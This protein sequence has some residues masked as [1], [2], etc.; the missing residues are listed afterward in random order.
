M[1]LEHVEIPFE[2]F[3][4]RHRHTRNVEDHARGFSGWEMRYNQ[5]TPGLFEG[6]ITELDLDG[7]QLIRDRANQAM[8]KSGQ[9]W[10]GAVTFSLPLAAKDH[11]FYCDGRAINVQSVLAGAGDQLPDLCTP[12]D[13]DLLCVAV[14]KSLLETMLAKQQRDLRL[15]L[16][17]VA[18]CFQLANFSCREELAS[19]INSVTDREGP[20]LLAH[21]AIR[22]GIRDTVLLH[23][24]DLIDS[25]E[26]TPLSSTARKR[27]VDRACE[28]ALS[29]RDNPPSIMDLCNHVGAS[30]RKLQYCFQET[31]GVNPVAYLRILRL[32]AV[33]RAL[34]QA[35]STITVQ[36]IA[37][38]WGFW[39]LS[40]FAAEYRQL[41]GERPS[42]TLSR[43]RQ[44]CADF[45]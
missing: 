13:V 27:I 24:L 15:D 21:T 2:R 20:G 41:F 10:D 16:N 34:L 45:G 36:D 5:V 12:A 14:D 40:R 43:A 28:F 22:A 33:H 18:G 29:H 17:V 4:L 3:G 30:R 11:S 8:V 19:L 31:L 39:H 9:S 26:V 37:A 7:M 32:N 25:E 42:D 38:N 1:H 44:Y 23:L 35:D 6:S